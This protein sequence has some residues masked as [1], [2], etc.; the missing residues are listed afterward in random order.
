MYMNKYASH[1]EY[2]Y[3]YIIFIYLCISNIYSVPDQT[4]QIGISRGLIHIFW[5][6]IYS[7][8]AVRVSFHFTLFHFVSF[9]FVLFLN[10]SSI[11]NRIV[12]SY[13]F[14]LLVF[15]Y[16][17]IHTYG[18]IYES[19]ESTFKSCIVI[20]IVYRLRIHIYIYIPHLIFI[21]FTTLFSLCR[22]VLHV[23]VCGV[24]CVC[25]CVNTLPSKRN[26]LSI[27]LSMHH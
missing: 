14:A 4:D 3:I 24:C 6:Y 12:L 20:I 8:R 22:V 2:V 9:R 21:K 26:Y 23:C 10:V 16:V 7:T 19:K 18:N 27:R 15:I 17:Y 5:I 25:V 1:I 11:S 13:R